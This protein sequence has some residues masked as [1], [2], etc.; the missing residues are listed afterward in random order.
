[1]L[2]LTRNHFRD[3]PTDPSSWLSLLGFNSLH[4]VSSGYYEITERTAPY[5]LHLTSFLYIR[6]LSIFL[7]L[8]GWLQIWAKLPSL[9]ISDISFIIKTLTPERC[10]TRFI[11]WGFCFLNRAFR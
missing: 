4:H 1:L 2:F 9:N 7:R 6:C 8:Y 10:L 11:Y 5:L 3:S